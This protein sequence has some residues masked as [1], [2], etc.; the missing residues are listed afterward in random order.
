MDL[1]VAAVVG[2]KLSH[3]F[4]GASL[5]VENQLRKGA[6]KVGPLGEVGSLKFDPTRGA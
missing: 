3:A 1:K 4:W 5:T 2:G 6:G